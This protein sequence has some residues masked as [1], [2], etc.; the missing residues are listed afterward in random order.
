MIFKCAEQNKIVLRLYYIVLYYI[1][2]YY[3]VLRLKIV[4]IVITSPTQQNKIIYVQ[5][6]REYLH[7]NSHLKYINKMILSLM[8]TQWLPIYNMLSW[9]LLIIWLT[10]SV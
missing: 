4:S 6:V 1:V 2:L 7:V 5:C 3:I 8:N 10:M 9:S